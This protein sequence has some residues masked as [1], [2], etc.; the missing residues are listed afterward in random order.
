MP[1]LA[2]T[3]GRM[4][5]ISTPRGR[6]FFYRLFAMG[7]REE[8]EFWSRQSP[9]SENP[10]VSAEYLD[11][12][13][14]ILSKRAFRTEYCAEFLDSSSAVFGIDFL[15]AVLGL[16]SVEIGE[17][18]FGIDWAR[19]TD[20]TAAIAVRGTKERCEVIHVEAWNALRWSEQVLRVAHLAASL[21]VRRVICDVTGLGDPVTE[22]LKKSAPQ[23][24]IDEFIFTRQSKTQIIDRLVW[25]LERECLRLPAHIDLLRQLE[26]FERQ[27]D[28]HG[29]KYEAAAGFHDDLVCALAMACSALPHGRN[30]GVLYKER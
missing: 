7:E 4:T 25:M 26:N 21:N 20:Y 11:L 30:L 16:P 18:V 22:N 9:S 14:E 12:Q 1:M 10:H 15:D 3:N 19:C 13:Q 27:P 23:V 17:V 6:D 2:A 29:V 28:E 8:N 24:A 5:L